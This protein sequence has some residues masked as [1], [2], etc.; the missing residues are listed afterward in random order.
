MVFCGF[1]SFVFVFFFQGYL[2]F[3]LIIGFTLFS[4]IEQVVLVGRAR[5]FS[6]TFFPSEYRLLPQI[7]SLRRLNSVFL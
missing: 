7:P 4:R 2:G 3:V 5:D 6:L 1:Y